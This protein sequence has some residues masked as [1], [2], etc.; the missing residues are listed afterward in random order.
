MPARIPH[1]DYCTR[2]RALG[3]IHGSKNVPTGGDIGAAGVSKLESPADA[4]E[5]LGRWGRLHLCPK[6]LV[7]DI[8]A[9]LMPDDY[10]ARPEHV[11][12][13]TVAAWDSNCPQH[14][15]QRFE[16]TDVAAALAERD[17]RIEKLEAEISALKERFAGAQVSSRSDT[18]IEHDAG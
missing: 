3:L 2:C 16:A 15:T 1:R 18:T 10:K 9:K 14:I 13:F 11:M 8:V 12:L 6:G 17:E 5:Q 4:D 7:A